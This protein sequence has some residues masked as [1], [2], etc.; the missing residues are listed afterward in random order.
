MLIK[1]VCGIHFADSGSVSFADTSIAPDTLSEIRRR[2]GY[3]IQDGGLYPHL[4]A[5]ES[6]TLAAEEQGQPVAQIAAR[7]EELAALA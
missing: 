2:I 1:L 5:R 3:V 6:I 7:T 4:T